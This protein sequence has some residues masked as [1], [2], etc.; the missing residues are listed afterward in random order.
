MKKLFRIYMFDKNNVKESM[1]ISKTNN[2]KNR[3]KKLKKSI[4][5]QDFSRFNHLKDVPLENIVIEVSVL[6]TT[7]GVC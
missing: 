1:I 6:V 4:E 2:P 3:I 7:E 5:N